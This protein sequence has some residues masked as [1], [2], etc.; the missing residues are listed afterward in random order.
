MKDKI[1]EVLHR[2][3]NPCNDNT[4]ES[5]ADEILALF[6]EEYEYVIIEKTVPVRKVGK[7]LVTAYHE[8]IDYAGIDPV[9]WGE[10]TL[11]VDWAYGK[12]VT[13][14]YSP[15]DRVNRYFEDE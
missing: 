1:L 8:P 13:V 10:V 5:I 2:T 15:L 11:G 9:K 12:D 4:Y 7:Y 3:I 6:E 14:Y